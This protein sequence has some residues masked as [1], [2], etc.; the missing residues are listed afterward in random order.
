V[1][2]SREAPVLAE[3]MCVGL[4]VHGRSVVGCMIDNE[5][6]EV[7][8][9]RIS[10]KLEMILY[11]V[12]SFPGSVAVAYEAGPRGDC[13]VKGWSGTTALG[14]V[15]MRRGCGPAVRPG[16]RAAGLRR[17]LRC[18]TER[19][20]PPGPPRYRDHRDGRNEPVPPVVDRMC[21]L[22]GIGTLTGFGLAVEIG[23]RGRFTGCTTPISGWCRRRPPA[24]PARLGRDHQDR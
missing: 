13:C 4:D 19:A 21:C 2:H 18:G 10:P 6:G 8:T 9:L 24:G 12:R 5:S 7:V 16:R 15:P 17:G 23:D 11:W 3:R 22:R 14:P 1:P 20:R